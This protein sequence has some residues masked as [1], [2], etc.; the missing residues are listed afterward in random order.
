MLVRRT[1]PV[2]L[3]ALA[4][5]TGLQAQTAAPSPVSAGFDTEAVW[6]DFER[7]ASATLEGRKTGSEGNRTARQLIVERFRQ[8]GLTPFGTD[9]QMPFTFS[10]QGAEQQGVNVVGLCRGR[11]SAD[12]RAIVVSAHYDHVGVRD[13][14][15]YPGADDNASGTA[16]LL[17]IASLCKRS[18]WQHDVVVA[19]FDAEEMGLQG[20]RAFVASPP[21]QKSRI[22][23]N[24]NMDMVSRSDARELYIAGTSYRPDVRS[25]LEPVAARS[26]VKVRFG[27]DQSKGAFDRDDW[28]MQS[29]HGPFHAAGIPFVYVGV[30]DHADYHKP[31]DTFDKV[32][33][34]FY[35]QVVATI[36]DA[37]GALDGSLP[38]ARQ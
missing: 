14:K 38:A 2:A 13:G 37:I 3:V 28:T 33:R 22:V 35:F 36:V 16:A 11:Q 7:L 20:A 18:P 26:A 30:E 27:H 1:I 10:R 12:A 29:D 9:F 24:V 6:K 19:A 34:T 23:L 32:D 8:A 25:V 5:G 17:A 15:T 31:T 4:L 21:I